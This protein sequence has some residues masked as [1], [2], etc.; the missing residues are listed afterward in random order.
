GEC[1]SMV[2]R[3]A[4]EFE[5]HQLYSELRQNQNRWDEAAE[6][7][8]L[9][10]KHQSLEPTGLIGLAKAQIHLKQWDKASD[11]V[12]KLERKAWPARFGN[13]RGEIHQLRVTIEQSRKQ[14]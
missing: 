13:V 5:S 11:T 9:V 12:Q 3:V 14:Q 6:H 4:K 10:A 8:E 1:R 2:E 7:W